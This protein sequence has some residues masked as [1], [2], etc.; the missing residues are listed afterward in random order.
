[1]ANSDKKLATMLYRSKSGILRILSRRKCGFEP[2]ALHLHMHIYKHYLLLHR[3][4]RSIKL[5][6]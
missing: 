3:T 1:M 4:E 6:C 2:K 5:G